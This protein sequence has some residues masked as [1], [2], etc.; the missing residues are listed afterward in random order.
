MILAAAAITP[1]DYQVDAREAI[2]RYFNKFKGNPLVLM[3]TGTGKSV[4]IGDFS[5][6][7]LFAYPRTRIMCVTHVETL[8]AQ[9]YAKFLQVW[10]TAPAGIY[11]A[12][13]ERRDTLQ[14]VIFAGIQSVYQ[15]PEVFGHI[16]ILI[17]DE[18][19]L[20]GPN[21]EA[22]YQKFIKALKA[23]NPHLKVIGFTATGWRMG[24]GELVGGGIFTDI[25]IDMTTPEAWNWFVDMGYLAPL[26]TKKTDFHLEAN[27]VKLTA[28][29]Y[30][31]G[32]LEKAVDKEHLTRMVVE[33]MLAKAHDRNQWMIFATGKKHCDHVAAMLAEYGEEA[34][35]IHSGKHNANELVKEYCAGN[36]RIAVSMNKLT[37]GVDAPGIDFIGN[38]RHTK[39]SAMW[40]QMLGRG[41]RPLYEE[42]YDLSTVE[43]RLAAM[44]A[45]MK[46]EGCLVADFARNIETLGP[47]NDPVIPPRVKKRAGGKG[48]APPPVQVACPACMTYCSANALVC[49]NCTYEFPIKVNHDRH[50]STA[51]V[52]VRAKAQ[53]E[54]RVEIVPVAHVTYAIHYRR[55]SGKP[56]SIR[57]SYYAPGMMRKYEEYVCF[58]HP[59]QKARSANWWR[60]R[61]PD[62][63]P[64]NTPAPETCNQA[65]EWLSHLKTPHAI[66]VWVNTKPQKVMNHEFA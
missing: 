15:R 12:G 43:G 49:P 55:N 46:P 1:R 37:T 38:L 40:V 50:A 36:A 42:G 66:H 35:S 31:L 4:V 63:W 58:E 62:I 16:D 39:S 44:A 34:L 27:G 30:N 41:T 60:E 19:H 53:E 20:I 54:P 7:C 47:I 29:E 51:E 18:A 8:I 22:M 33:E 56:P 59:T 2:W 26:T 32:E 9:N 10:P 25:A 28:G 23:R 61:I 64:K 11:S 21:A 65:L 57:V 45:S 5:R 6:S 24:F 52:M 14:Q 13:L 17:V 48:S 3:P